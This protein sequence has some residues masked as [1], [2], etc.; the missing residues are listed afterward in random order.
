[1]RHVLVIGAGPAGLAACASALDAGAQVTLLDSD[2]ELG[3][4]YWRH[5]PRERTGADDLRL[6]HGWERFV[7]LR[8]RLYLGGCRILTST[9][10]W[11]VETDAAAPVGLAVN[12][13]RGLADGVGREAVRLAPDAIVLATGAHDRTL[14]FPGWELPG[15]FTGGAAQALMKRERVRVGE[16]VVV[17]GAGP[18]LL[19]VAASVTHGGARLVGVYEAAGAGTLIRGWAPRPWRLLGVAHKSSELVGYASGL[20]R[21]RVPYRLGHGVVAAHGDDRVEAVTIAR[22]APDWSPLSGT[23]RRVEVDAVCVT[24]GFTPRLELAIACGCELTASRFVSV[25][26]DQATNAPGVYAAGEL[27][28]IGGADAA[29]AEGIV[30]GHISA[31][32][33]RAELRSAMRDRARTADFADRIEAAHGIRPGWSAWLDEETLVC[34]CEE[35][36]Y[37]T[38]C[39]VAR[40]TASDSLRSLKLS[41]RVGLGPCQGR[42]CGRT[43]ELLLTQLSPDGV[44][45]DDATT[46]RRPV[47]VPTRVGD[48]ARLAS[49]GSERLPSQMGES[50]SST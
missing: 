8:E 41:T 19:P 10:V 12:A 26:A 29:L 7:A 33:E 20:V 50:P 37:G 3:G 48:L 49:P 47:V 23:E 1:M 40:G 21:G 36:S 5:V 46:D 14:P 18:F 35:V 17:A 32:G 16:R 4:Q 2:R 44:L 34:R 43:A 30:A 38:V 28:G 9:Q 24:H 11:S 25:D 42:V 22:L 39:R 31:G 15:V 45:R 6:H 27:T 13:F